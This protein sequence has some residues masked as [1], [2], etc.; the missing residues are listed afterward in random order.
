MKLEK[1]W[2][3]MCYELAKLYKKKTAEVLTK[4]DWIFQQQ[5]F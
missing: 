5:Q 3:K 4:K 2:A 1:G